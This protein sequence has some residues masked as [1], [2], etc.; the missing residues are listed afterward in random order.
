MTKQD[1]LAEL[2]ETRTDLPR[3][4]EAASRTDLWYLVVPG[5][6]VKAWEDREPRIWLKV[7]G[8]LAAQGKTIVELERRA[9]G[10]PTRTGRTRPSVESQECAK[11][12]MVTLPGHLMQHF[13]RCLDHDPTTCEACRPVSSDTPSRG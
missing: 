8:W 12:G 9:N 5:G 1:L 10:G 2:R 6:A 4:I 13:V 7:L 11:C 3:F